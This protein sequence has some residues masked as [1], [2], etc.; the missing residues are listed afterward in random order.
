MILPLNAR[1][2]THKEILEL[3]TLLIG[4]NQSIVQLQLQSEIAKNKLKGI[5]ES[6]G[7]LKDV[8]CDVINQE[9]KY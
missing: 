5:Y 6:E 1:K 4:F 2:K 7:I 9:L 8:Q 3:N